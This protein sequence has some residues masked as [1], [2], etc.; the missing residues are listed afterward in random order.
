[1]YMQ[2]NNGGSFVIITSLSKHVAG[3]H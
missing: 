1:M 3:A 2:Y